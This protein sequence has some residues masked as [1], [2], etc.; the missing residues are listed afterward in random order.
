[1]R[2]ARPIADALFRPYLSADAILDCPGRRCSEVL[3]ARFLARVAPPF[4]LAKSGTRGAGRRHHERRGRNALPR[5]G[6]SGR[7]GSHRRRFAEPGHHARVA[8]VRHQR[9]LTG[10]RSGPEC[11]LARVPTAP[12]KGAHCP[13]RGGAPVLLPTALTRGARQP[14]V[15]LRHLSA[16]DAGPLRYEPRAGGPRESDGL[17][18]VRGPS[19]PASKRPFAPAGFG[20]QARSTVVLEA[21]A[22]SSSATGGREEVVCFRQRSRRRG[23]DRRK[24]SPP[25]EASPLRPRAPGRATTEFRPSTDGESVAVVAHH[26][27][28]LVVEEGGGLVVHGSPARQPPEGRT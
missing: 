10:E 24:T 9:P 6:R 4:A 21:T 26:L 7:D 28:C 22:T 12:A 13:W 1:M 25:G 2:G 18:P 17:F 3:T 19:A 15:A 16:S 14:A 5:L 8:S 20:S 23:S 11:R 27:G